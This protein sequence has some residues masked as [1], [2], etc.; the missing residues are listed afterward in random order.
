MQRKR[1]GKGENE[2]SKAGETRLTGRKGKKRRGKKEYAEGKEKS[3]AQEARRNTKIRHVWCQL[4]HGTKIMPWC[5][6]QYALITRDA[7]WR[8][9]IKRH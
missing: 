7:G 6:L 8:M 5:A 4:F 9:V 1:G 3:K 2:E